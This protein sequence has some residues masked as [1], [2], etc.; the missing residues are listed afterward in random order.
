MSFIQLTGH[1]GMFT[2]R[3][4]DAEVDIGIKQEEQRLYQKIYRKTVSVL[5]KSHAH[6]ISGIIVLYSSVNW[7]Y[8]SKA[9]V[10]CR[11]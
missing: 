1:A 3:E 6:C 4:V 2:R 10:I 5:N 7:V 8:D 9:K 11:R